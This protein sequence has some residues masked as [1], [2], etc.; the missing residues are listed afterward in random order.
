MSRNVKKDL[1]KQIKRFAETGKLPKDH[2]VL[3]ARFVPRSYRGE[4]EDGVNIETAGDG[5]ANVPERRSFTSRE[6]Q[7]LA[8]GHVLF[9]ASLSAV[10]RKVF[11]LHMLGGMSRKE[12]AAILGVSRQRVSA[13]V[14]QIR[15]HAKNVIAEELA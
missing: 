10:Q 4:Q 2:D 8:D 13:A 5:L 3:P 1:Q 6:A 15:R 12:T 11:D 9:L 14:I 7:A